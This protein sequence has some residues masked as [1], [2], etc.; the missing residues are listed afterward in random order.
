M[1]DKKILSPLGFYGTIWFILL[2][3]GTLLRS[4][5][6]SR[7]L[8]YDEVW[9]LAYFSGKSAWQI[10]TSRDLINLH[11]LNHSWVAF[12][13]MASFSELQYRIWV[14]IAGLLTLILAAELAIFSFS[15]QTVCS[16]YYLSL[17]NSSYI[18]LLFTNSSWL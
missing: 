17:R 13:D 11:A 9:P 6:L 2:L 4:I 5:G 16:Y 10:L 14:W 18:G 15:E 3:F 8:E 12:M 7:G 1:N